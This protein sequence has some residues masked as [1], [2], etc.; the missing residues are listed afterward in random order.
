MRSL[1]ISLL[2]F[3]VFV[4][5]SCSFTPK[6]SLAFLGSGAEQAVATQRYAVPM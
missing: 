4:A 5:A 2:L 3:A 6:S 1:K